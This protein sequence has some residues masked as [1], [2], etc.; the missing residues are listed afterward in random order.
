MTTATPDF[1]AARPAGPAT[2]K[3]LTLDQLVAPLEI[4]AELCRAR[5]APKW[6]LILPI[7]MLAAFTVPALPMDGHG[8]AGT[9]GARIA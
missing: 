7:A 4:P 9:A 5:W 2:D 8:A 6:A 1:A 3:A